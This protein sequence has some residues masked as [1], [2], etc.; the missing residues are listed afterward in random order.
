MLT[1]DLPVTADSSEPLGFS[2]LQRDLFLEQVRRPRS[3]HLNI[4]GYVRMSGIDAGRLC[5]AHQRLVTEEECFR[6]RL[7]GSSTSPVFTLT[8]EAQPPLPILDFS[9]AEAPLRAA[10]DHLGSLMGQPFDLGGPLYRAA[11]VQVSEQ[12]WWYIGVAHH[13]IMDGWS[14]VTWARRLGERY[15]GQAGDAPRFSLREFCGERARYLDSERH[16]ADLRYWVEHLDAH[17]GPLLRPFYPARLV[18][19]VARSVR[20]SRVIPGQVMDRLRG[21]AQAL[22]TSVP[23]VV[24]GILGYYLAQAYD[25]QTVAIGLPVHGRRG[26]AQRG[27]IGPYLSVLPLLFEAGPELPLSAVVRNVVRAQKSDFRHQRLTVGDVT[28][29]AASSAWGERPYDVAFSYLVR[30]EELRF[31][32]DLVNLQFAHTPEQRTPVLLTLFEAPEQGAATLQVDLSAGYFDEREGALLADRLASLFARWTPED[33]DRTDVPILDDTEFERHLKPV[34]AEPLPLQ[35]RSIDALFIS[36]AHDHP[37]AVALEVDGQTWTYARL[38]EDVLQLAQVLQS[39]TQGERAAVGICMRRSHR[40]VV[41][42]LAVLR[43]GCA[44]VPLDP[45]YPRERLEQF[46]SEVECGLVLVDELGAAALR[47]LALTTLDLSAGVPAPPSSPGGDVVRSP[48]DRAYVIFTS[49]STGRPKAVDIRHANTL[50]LLAWATRYFTPEE[51]K[52]TYASTSLNFDLSVFELF[53]PLCHGHTCVLSTSDAVRSQVPAGVTLVNTVPS[54]A[55]VLLEQRALPESVRT[56]NLAGEALEGALVNRLLA[57]TSCTRVVNLYGPTEDTTYSTAASFSEPVVERPHI[58]RII[59]GSGGFILN[60]RRRLVPYGCMGELWLSGAGLAAG[61]IGREEETRERFVWLT[62]PT[63]ERLRCYRTGDLA[64]YIAPGELQFYGRTD[65]QVKV[66]GFRIE[67]AEIEN[68]LCR[69]PGVGRAAVAPHGED[70]AKVLVAYLEFAQDAAPTHAE[71]RA[72]LASQLPAYMVPARYVA[73]KALPL[74]SNG[75]IDRRRLGLELGV[76]LAAR[77]SGPAR[78]LTGIESRIAAIW[79]SLLKCD[80]SSAESHFFELGGQSLLAMR[81]LLEVRRELGVDIPLPRFLESP[82]LEK[83]AWLVTECAPRSTLVAHR[84][85]ADQRQRP[86]FGQRGLWFVDRVNGASPEYNVGASFQVS[87]PLHLAALERALRRLVEDHAVLRSR[88]VEEGGDVALAPLPSS[89]FTLVFDE[90]TRVDVRSGEAALEAYAA[91]RVGQPFALGEDLL[92]RAWVVAL[93]EDQHL[94]SLAAHHSAVD[95]WSLELLLKELQASYSAELVGAP[96]AQAQGRYAYADY[97]YSQAQWLAAGELEAGLLHWT[98][99]LKGAPAAHS[100]PLARPRSRKWDAAGDYLVRSLPGTLVRR[101]DAVSKKLGVSR[102]CSFHAALALHLSHASGVSDIVIGTPAASRS[103]AEVRD[104]VGMFVNPVL[105][106]TRSSAQASFAEA[107]RASAVDIRQAL[108]HQHVPFDLVVSRVAP[109]RVPGLSPLFQLWFVWNDFESL[110]PQ[111]PGCETR[112]LARSTHSHTKYDLTV[113]VTSREGELVV[114]WHYASALFDRAAIVSLADQF[115]RR[116]GALLA[117]YEAPVSKALSPEVTAAPPPNRTQGEGTAPLLQLFQRS[118][119]Q[120]GEATALVKNDQRLTYAQLDAWSGALAER[121]LRAGLRGRVALLTTPT[122]ETVVAIL[123]LLKAGLSYVPLDLAL[124]FERMLLI[125]RDSEAGAVLCEGDRLDVGQRLSRAVDRPVHVIESA[126]STAPSAFALPAR[127]DNPEA[128]VLYTSGSTGRSKGVVQRQDAVAHFAMAYSAQI[129]ASP[130]D[131]L[132]LVS[133][134]AFDAAAMDL[135][136]GFGVGATIVLLDLKQTARNEV[137]R[138]MATNR[139]TVVHGTPTVLSFLFP[140]GDSGLPGLQPRALV[141]GGESVSKSVFRALQARF[142]EAALVISYGCTEASFISFARPARAEDV[143]DLGKP[144]AACAVTV[145]DEALRPVD[146]GTVGRVGVETPYSAAG[147]LNEAELSAE[148][149]RVVDGRRYFIPGDYG[150]LT[151][152]G[153]LEF[154]GRRDQQ[155]KLRGIRIDLLEI[156]ATLK[157]NARV[158]RCAVI[159]RRDEEGTCTE[160]LAY[161][162]ER[163]PVAPEAPAFGAEL[164]GFLGSQLPA[165]M[166]PTFCILEGMPLTPSGKID[167]KTLATSPPV[168]TVEAV[169]TA[170]RPAT[171]QELEVAEVWSE[172]LK[173]PVPGLQ[174]D[175]FDLGGHSML[176]MQLTHALEVRFG[177]RLPISLLFEGATIESCSKLIE[178]GL[179][180]QRERNA[181]SPDDTDEFIEI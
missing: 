128:C 53:A 166:L 90:P 32:Q 126:S 63:G 58:G 144:I 110:V 95:G 100:L 22:G 66:R 36:A 69:H 162:T 168:A 87:G 176:L 85:P 131:V 64:R 77:E 8:R 111:F 123:G 67:L 99:K 112:E 40:M 154:S 161:V 44:Y 150:R 60:S 125:L 96:E 172:V 158:E 179:L 127:P 31:G 157:A 14:L 48:E 86:S 29:A 70:E 108:E 159:P 91:S 24:V 1:R 2:S 101:L 132:T 155:V 73:V 137:L 148:H 102:F 12:D 27:H 178:Q 28:Q 98:E 175:F 151:S 115:E 113:D 54:V 7:D 9:T 119:E 116:L 104:T 78:P 33:L 35:A 61:Y 167:R 177:V 117:E 39:R 94:L 135:W 76:E 17:P 10:E 147:Y 57:G 138:Q 3:A 163:K 164:R 92:F 142:P 56:I 52:R 83:T 30:D 139:V 59:Q 109:P 114:R 93:G 50:A 130:R 80:V 38:L 11:L 43:A 15:S 68:L 88:F 103:L 13:V 97:A 5:E 79:S 133:S 46:T 149:F 6:A 156:E 89:R 84:L 72:A 146:V 118:V 16:Q 71:L 160:L 37:E 153:S 129:E 62:L 171:A 65:D 82:S 81:M 25:K 143:M 120:Q 51:L 105:L 41:S 122:V 26:A 134:F 55:R 180:L 145:F 19:D 170:E 34:G 121:L 106:R 23:Q 74:T 173:R 18:E 136:C 169:A 49:G 174:V 75:K 141:F 165:Y 47:G 20:I 42:V 107:V 4:G 140:P 181:T 21:V 124:P 45:A 152:E